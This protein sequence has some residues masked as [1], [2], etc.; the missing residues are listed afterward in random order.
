[1]RSEFYI[2][3]EK[4]QFYYLL[5]MVKTHCILTMLHEEILWEK[6]KIEF[7][8]GFPADFFGSGSF[9]IVRYSS[10]QRYRTL[11]RDFRHG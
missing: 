7:L 5:I 8:G 2:E 1:M 6:F 4:S 9:G 3:T 11:E 10:F